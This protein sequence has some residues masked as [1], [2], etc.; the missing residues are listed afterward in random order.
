MTQQTQP[1]KAPSLTA[2]LSMSACS[3]AAVIVAV[4]CGTASTL[5][6]VTFRGRE[7][8]LLKR[9]AKRSLRLAAPLEPPPPL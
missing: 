2:Y 1:T 9:T 8:T 5:P 4:P 7:A 6:S 3:P